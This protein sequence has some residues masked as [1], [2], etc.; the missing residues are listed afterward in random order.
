MAGESL[1]TDPSQ[2]WNGQ[3]L[4]ED[5]FGEVAAPPVAAALPRRL[6]GF[7]FW[8]GEQPL[9]AAIEPVYSAATPRALDLFLGPA[10]ESPVTVET[11]SKSS[12]G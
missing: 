12:R 9:L 7:P 6:G 11:G 5:P 1:P 8:R 10:E 4:A 2:F 3:A